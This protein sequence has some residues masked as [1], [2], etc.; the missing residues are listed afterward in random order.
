MNFSGRRV[1]VVGLERSG[2]AAAR[3]LNRYKAV[4]SACDKKDAADI[5][6]D[7]EELKRLGIT[8]YTG[9]YPNVSRKD[10]DLLVASPGV[11]LTIEPFAVA[12]REGIPIIGEVELA[13][14]LKSPGV[15]MLAVTG[16]NGKTTTTALL[17]KIL[18]CDGR[19]S[20]MGGNIGVALSAM[21][22][23]L[24]AGI[25]SVEMSSFQLESIDEF[26]PEI[27]GILNITPDHLD[28]HK[29]MDAYI[30]AKAR[31]F[32]NQLPEDYTVL[33]Y[34][35]AILKKM[36]LDC[37]AK[38]FYF[39]TDRILGEGAFAEN[40][41]VTVVVEKTKHVI[42]PLEQLTLRGK[43]NL[44]NILCA[45]MMAVLAGVKKEALQEALTTFPGVRHRMENVAAKGGVLYINDSKATNP[46]SAM[47]ALASFQEPIVLI[48]GGRNKGSDFTA[49]AHDIKARV[50]ELVLLGEARDEIKHA[51]M[52]LD[53]KNIHEVEDFETAVIT[54]SK[55]ARP[56]DVVLLS[57][58][59]AS[60][61]MFPSYEHRGDLFCEVV[62]SL[63]VE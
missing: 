34:E 48:A 5:R 57:P 11:P 18:E 53:F 1:L 27:C 51:V 20:L 29:T 46:D 32:E 4:V 16:T 21:V 60:W 40:G 9:M 23:D 56:G 31:I 50:R 22:A 33:N 44:E 6:T 36:A 45:S 55:L 17:Q 37:P 54:A 39:S 14:Q 35:D 49:L 58:A 28:R 3:I 19:H 8:I 61:D 62:R 15:E 41:W 42:C 7:L 10:F 12:Q 30:A 59:C 25:I 63:P 43:H 13:Y 47:K 26:R 24:A 52:E 2:S 38:V